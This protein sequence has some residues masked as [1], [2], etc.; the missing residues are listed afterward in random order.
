MFT[1]KLIKDNVAIAKCIVYTNDIHKNEIEISE[2]QYNEINEFPSK[3]TFDKDG[4]IIT[5][6]KTELPIEEYVEPIHKPTTEDRL[7]ALEDALLFLT[8]GG[9][10]NV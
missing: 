10:P 5:W 2:E 9:I 1:L 8:L 4:K 6:K 3:L 7:K